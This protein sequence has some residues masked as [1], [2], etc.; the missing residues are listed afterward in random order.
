MRRK[1]V[2]GNWKMHG[3]H[4]ANAEL[5]AG[6]LGAGPFGCDVAVCVPFPYLSQA[7]VA[8]AASDIRWGAQDVSAQAKG[9]YTGEEIGR[10]S[11]RERVS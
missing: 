11:C 3:S 4:T 9:A 10:A 7:A 1:L 5:L 8:L 6:I 2:A